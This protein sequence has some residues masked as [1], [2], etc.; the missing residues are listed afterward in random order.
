MNEF[1]PEEDPN[2]KHLSRLNL[3]N[4]PRREVQVQRLTLDTAAR[5]SQKAGLGLRSRQCRISLCGQKP[6]LDRKSENSQA[7][8]I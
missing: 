5:P 6:A 3:E 2:D 7:G 8:V 4:L 1:R